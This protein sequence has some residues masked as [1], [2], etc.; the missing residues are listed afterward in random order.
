MHI[1]SHCIGMPSAF[2][3][4]DTWT[5]PADPQNHSYSGNEESANLGFASYLLTW[6]RM[7]QT[8]TVENLFE[9]VR[10]CVE[11]LGETGPDADT[12]LGRL[13]IGCLAFEAYKKANPSAVLSTAVI[14]G[15]P[16]PECSADRILINHVCVPR[17][18]CPAGQVVSAQ[19]GCEIIS[20]WPALSTHRYTADVERSAAAG[21]QDGRH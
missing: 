16:L 2:F 5:D 3:V 17:V 1:E 13:D 7:P 12:G 14:H 4:R 8:V 20:H 21:F 15:S 10:G 6:E 18:V 11:D 9:V 19:N